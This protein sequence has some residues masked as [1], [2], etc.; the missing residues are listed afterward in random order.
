[1]KD[2]NVPNM[3]SITIRE[4]HFNKKT[5]NFSPASW[6]PIKNC[7]SRIRARSKGAFGNLCPTGPGALRKRGANKEEWVAQNFVDIMVKIHNKI[8]TINSPNPREGP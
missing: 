7:E 1:M 8:Q 3:L 5:K 2:F 6:L 4:L